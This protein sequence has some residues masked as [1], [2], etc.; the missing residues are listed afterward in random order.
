MPASCIAALAWSI[1]TSCLW[2]ALWRLYVDQRVSLPNVQSR[3]FEGRKTSLL[4]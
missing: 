4:L 1:A 2:Q 3:L